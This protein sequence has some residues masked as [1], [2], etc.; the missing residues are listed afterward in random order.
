MEG[1]EA[2]ERLKAEG[3]T[4]YQKQKYGAAVDRYTEAILLC[5]DWSVLLIN[6][7]LCQKHRGR[8]EEVEGDSRKALD[9][10]PRNMKGHYFLGQAL[11]HRSDLDGSI[12]HLTK[13][14]ELAREQGDSIRD[15]IWRELAKAKYSRWQVESATRKA[16]QAMLQERLNALLLQ[17]HRRALA[18]AG[19]NR[20]EVQTQHDHEVAA[21]KRLLE[22]GEESYK[23]YEPD[24]AY[25]CRLTMEVFREPVITPS[26]LSYEQG[27]LQEHLNKVGNFDP[28]T[29]KPMTANDIVPNL[30]LRA[31]TEHYL[32]NNPWAWADVC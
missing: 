10:Q 24:N 4:A 11:R 22:L 1:R 21:F 6:R 5:P 25:T 16:E 19:D 7:A 31:A 26:G 30:A 29:R 15:S 13:A 18:E 17:D 2:A 20:A 28:V 12:Q 23:E 8:W 27:A 14:L 3:N 9:L 32:D